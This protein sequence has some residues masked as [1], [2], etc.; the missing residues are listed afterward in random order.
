MTPKVVAQNFMFI[1]CNPQFPGSVLIVG[2]TFKA[3]SRGI[4]ENL[5]AAIVET[6]PHGFLPIKGRSADFPT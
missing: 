3:P 2:T 1:A 6:V 4:L 5:R